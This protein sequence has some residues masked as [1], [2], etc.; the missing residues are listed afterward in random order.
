VKLTP[1]WFV[2]LNATLWL[3]GVNANPD[4]FGVTAYVPL[5]NPVNV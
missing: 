1:V 2:P 5:G 3:T 4:L